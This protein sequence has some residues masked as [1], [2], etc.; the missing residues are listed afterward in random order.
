MRERDI[1]RERETVRERETLREREG[2]GFCK[3][4]F[5]ISILHV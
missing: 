5:H 1:E 3:L 4:C 2:D